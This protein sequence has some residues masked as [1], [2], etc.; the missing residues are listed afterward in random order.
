MRA[1]APTDPT[2][3][4]VAVRDSSTRTVLT[5]PHRMSVSTLTGF[6][7]A[8]TTAVAARNAFA[9]MHSVFGMNSPDAPNRS[10]RYAFGVNPS[11][12]VLASSFAPGH[13]A[14][15]VAAANEMPDKAF[16]AEIENSLGSESARG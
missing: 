16:A 8:S 12:V 11:G 4:K 5:G 9:V 15:N 1:S 14:M 6:P 13:L 3:S 10:L 2:Q 7:V